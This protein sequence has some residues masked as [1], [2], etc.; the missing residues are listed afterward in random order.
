MDLIGNDAVLVTHDGEVVSVDSLTGKITVF[1]FAAAWCGDCRKFTPM[2]RDFYVHA[3]RLGI[4]IV[5]VSS[6]PDE[7]QRAAHMR[8]SHGPWLSL[9]SV[10]LYG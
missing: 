9:R 6:D 4:E 3:H 5:L 2:L 1:Y 10:I 7:S 8:D